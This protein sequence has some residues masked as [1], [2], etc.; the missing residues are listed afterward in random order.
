MNKH[1]HWF[2]QI[3]EE[4]LQETAEM[5]AQAKLGLNSHAP[6]QPAEI[7]NLR[8][9]GRTMPDSQLSGIEQHQCKAEI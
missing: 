6:F 9:Q 7:T 1:I 3:R 5:D 8:D 4:E 2:E